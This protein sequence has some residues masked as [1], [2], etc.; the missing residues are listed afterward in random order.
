MIAWTFLRTR[1]I[2]AAIR[3]PMKN[4]TGMQTGARFT[5]I[6]DSST[7]KDMTSIP[8]DKKELRLAIWNEQLYARPLNKDM[9]IMDAILTKLLHTSDQPLRDELRNSLDR[10]QFRVKFASLLQEAND[11]PD[12]TE[13][14]SQESL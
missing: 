7:T 3:H 10:W 6:T 9:Q 14:A 11:L 13:E 8:D 5:T 4:T 12:E 2:S 1:T